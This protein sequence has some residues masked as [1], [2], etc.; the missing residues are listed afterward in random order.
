MGAIGIGVALAVLG[1]SRF[2]LLLRRASAATARDI[3]AVSGQWIAEQRAS[4]WNT[5]V[6]DQAPNFASSGVGMTTM[7]PS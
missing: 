4:Q 6:A 1:W 5:R 7:E 2:V 3:G